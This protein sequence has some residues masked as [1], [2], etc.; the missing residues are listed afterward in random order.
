MS[1]NPAD[2]ANKTNGVDSSSNAER[3]VDWL[4]SL[5]NEE[6]AEATARAVGLTSES[7]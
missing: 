2:G 5:S 1:S 4:A 7:H 3:T 6:L